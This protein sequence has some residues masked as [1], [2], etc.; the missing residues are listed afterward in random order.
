MFEKMIENY[1]NKITKNDILNYASLKQITL[2]NEEVELLYDTIKKKWRVLLYE[3][4]TPIFNDLKTK[5]N[6][7]TYEKGIEL[8]YQMKQKYQSFL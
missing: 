8:Y 7:T 2:S 3:N 1:I 6:S 5:L 4:P